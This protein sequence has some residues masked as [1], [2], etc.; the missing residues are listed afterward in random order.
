M[1]II[2]DGVCVCVWT[3]LFRQHIRGRL[4][5]YIHINMCTWIYAQHM[6]V[7]GYQFHFPK[8]SSI[9][10]CGIFVLESCKWIGVWRES[11]V[12]FLLVMSQLWAPFALN[13]CVCVCALH[14]VHTV[15]FSAL[16]HQFSS[17]LFGNHVPIIHCLLVN[18]SAIVLLL[19]LLLSPI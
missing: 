3:L 5:Y 18:H 13:D 12:M 10:I 9:W 6:S 17:L 14:T 2:L 16:Y 1:Y 8:T 7:R 15:D 11:D 19:L 4:K